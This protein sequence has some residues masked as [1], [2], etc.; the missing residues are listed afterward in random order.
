MERVCLVPSMM[1][2]LGASLL[3]DSLLAALVREEMQSIEPKKKHNPDVTAGSFS[4]K[5]NSTCDVI[6]LN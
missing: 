4:T 1:L 6:Y 2:F 3:L 5:T